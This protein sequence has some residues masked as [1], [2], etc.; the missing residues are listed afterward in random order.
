MYGIDDLK[1][2][3]VHNSSFGK[4]K[5]IVFKTKDNHVSVISGDDACYSDV[6]NM[7]DEYMRREESSLNT[8][9]A[10]NAEWVVPHRGEIKKLSDTQLRLLRAAMTSFYK[11]VYNGNHRDDVGLYGYSG[12][13]TTKT[14]HALIDRG[15]LETMSGK[16]GE[17]YGGTKVRLT[18]KGYWTGIKLLK[19]RYSD[20]VRAQ[21]AAQVGKQQRMN[22]GKRVENAIADL[23]LKVSWIVEMQD[24]VFNDKRVFDLIGVAGGEKIVATFKGDRVSSVRTN[25]TYLQAMSR[26]VSLST[27]LLELVALES[28]LQRR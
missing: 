13:G 7:L 26:Q 22:A 1:S 10:Y 24:Q 27:A 20:Y 14:L 19:Y 3:S 2:I 28:E 8:A 5:K 6:R 25:R 21:G 15:L 9:S 4:V 23:E 18:A 16:L 12:I 11:A 17:V